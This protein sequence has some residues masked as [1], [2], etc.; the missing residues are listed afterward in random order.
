MKQI[1]RYIPLL[2]LALAWELVAVFHLVSS[3]ALP[4]LTDVVKAWIGMI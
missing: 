3:T 2:L 1:V 4:S